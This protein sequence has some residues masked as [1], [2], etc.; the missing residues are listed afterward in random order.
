MN[1][2]ENLHIIYFAISNPHLQ[3]NAFTKMHETLIS[4]NYLNRLENRM[5]CVLDTP[6]HK[7]ITVLWINVYW[8]TSIQYLKVFDVAH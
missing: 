1:D 8:F 2:S 6:F 7:F 5:F 3:I 4:E